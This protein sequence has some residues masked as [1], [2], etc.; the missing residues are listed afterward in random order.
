M[1]DWSVKTTSFHSATHILLSSHHWRRRRLWFWV[2]DRPSNGRLSDRPL[3]CKGVE[4]YAQTLNDALQTQCAV[5]RF[6]VR[7]SD[8]SLSCAQCACPPVQWCSE[9]DT[10]DHVGPSYHPT[11]N[12]HISA[13]Q[14]FD[15]VQHSY[16]FP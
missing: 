1:R 2:K 6:V 5:L 12:G 14:L 15:F 10:I 3:C 9:V 8:P 7:L 13:L 16:R 4:W 11:S